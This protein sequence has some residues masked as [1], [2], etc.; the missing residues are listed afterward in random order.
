MVSIA[1]VPKQIR[2]AVCK[3]LEMSDPYVLGLSPDK[4]NVFLV[5]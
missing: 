4:P 5:C 3:T 1:T 2:V